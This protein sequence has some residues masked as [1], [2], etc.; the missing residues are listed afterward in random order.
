MTKFK[1]FFNIKG[2]YVFDFND[3]RVALTVLNVILI[4]KFGLSV[5]LIGLAIAVFGTIRDMICEE[6]KINSTI[7]HAMM[8]I[9][10]AY[11]VSLM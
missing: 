7:Q 2:K 11:F 3:I 10:N 6:R 5:A 1:K 8:I 4:L 9:L